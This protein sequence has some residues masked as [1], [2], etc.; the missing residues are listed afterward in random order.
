MSRRTTAKRLID[1]KERQENSLATS[2]S[3]ESTTPTDTQPDFHPFDLPA[4]F[5][6]EPE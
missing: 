3:E 4:Q 5:A 6:S 2:E 1:D